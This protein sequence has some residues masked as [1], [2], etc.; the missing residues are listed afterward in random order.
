MKPAM[1]VDIVF[2]IWRQGDGDKRM[3]YIENEF[4]A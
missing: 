1:V 3:G 2:G 4:V